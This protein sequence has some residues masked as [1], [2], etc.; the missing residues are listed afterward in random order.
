MKPQ[1]PAVMN[2]LSTICRF[3]G[4]IL[5]YDRAKALG[6][7]GGV[8][9][10]VC[11]V[12]LQV[13]IY[14]GSLESMTLMINRSTADLWIVP[15]GVHNLDDSQFLPE[16]VLYQVRSAPGVLRVERLNVV[17]ASWQDDLGGR[18]G[19]QV[20]GF[21]SD[22]ELLR[23]WNVV[24]GS[25]ADLRRDRTVIID[26]GDRSRLRVRGVGD[27]SEIFLFREAGMQARVVGMTERVHA[28]TRTPIVMTSYENSL[29]FA[30]APPDRFNHLLVRLAAGA[31]R[32]RVRQSLRADIG[33]IDVYL[34]EEFAGVSRAYY[35]EFTG[36]GS[37]LL[38]SAFV[39]GTIGTGVMA[40]F[41]YMITAAHTGEYA[42]LKALGVPNARVL[43]LVVAQALFLGFFGYVFGA[44][45]ALLGRALLEERNLTV[46]VGPGLLA[47]SLAGALIACLIAAL[48]P[49]LKI[50]HTQP[51]FVFQS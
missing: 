1:E 38:T 3:A 17:F 12:L 31:D 20:V 45:V 6:G 44:C 32:E 47:A 8:A 36:I 30:H 18:I 2:D 22:G 43:A 26:A 39:G 19:I 9:C 4:K 34:P 23:P 10:A 33:L 15:R 5:L 13:G 40:I 14:H 11:L 27:E 51:G 41:L 21:E 42:T 25:T 35:T 29:A 49:A 16:Y 48:L 28:F 7:L 24:V 37:A 46:S 50:V